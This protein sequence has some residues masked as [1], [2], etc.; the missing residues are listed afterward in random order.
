MTWFKLHSD[1]RNDPK[2]KRLPITERY[3]FIVLLCLASESETR[4]TITGL[5]DDDI[6]FELEMQSEDWQT[7]KAKFKA[8]GFIDFTKDQ[9]LI[10]NWN[11]RQYD[12]PS[13]HPE[14]T[15]QRKRLQR[16]KIKFSNTE[17]VTPMSRDVTPMSRTRVDQSRSEESRS[18][19]IREEKEKNK[20]TF[21]SDLPDQNQEAMQPELKSSVAIANQERP[22]PLPPAQKVY[23][24]PMG[25]RFKSGKK[26]YWQKTISDRP[27][28]QELLTDWA[29]TQDCKFGFKESLLIAQMEYLKKWDKPCERGDA[30]GSLANYIKNDDRTSFD[31]RV[32]AAIAYEQALACNPTIKQSQ[33]TES[34]K[35]EPYI[36]KV[37]EVD[38]NGMVL[39]VDCRWEHYYPM[40]VKAN[41]DNGNI[42]IVWGMI[43]THPPDP[44]DE[45]CQKFLAKANGDTGKL[46]KLLTAKHLADSSFAS[47]PIQA[48]NFANA[49]DSLIAALNQEIQKSL[50]QA[51]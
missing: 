39:V 1:F 22:T 7:L 36:P 35:Q 46:A 8:K 34:P 2:I 48:E 13:D 44:V 4:G 29:G 25:D 41:P 31:L 23:A 15:K 37:G 18:E 38:A 51:A 42:A 43:N 26:H 40:T 3:A 9:V 30:M 47:Y 28:W 33:D 32:D 12:K 16:E 45:R 6:A 10:R 27:E 24:D 50:L 21:F 11:K 17:D 14:A 49:K 5:D 19:E 20:E